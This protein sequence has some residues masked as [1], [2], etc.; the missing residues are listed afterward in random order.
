MPSCVCLSEHFYKCWSTISHVFNSVCALR[1]HFYESE[2]QQG[3]SRDFWG[4]QCL[5]E[6]VSVSKMFP[7]DICHHLIWPGEKA[8]VKKE[9]NPLSHIMTF[10]GVTNNLCTSGGKHPCMELSWMCGMPLKPILTLNLSASIKNLN[11]KTVKVRKRNSPDKI[12]LPPHT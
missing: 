4:Y 1:M 6:C 11:F 8:G 3:V 12:L 10:L 2:K 7:K 9:G 5:V